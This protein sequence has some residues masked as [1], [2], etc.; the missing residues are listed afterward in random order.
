M[1]NHLLKALPVSIKTR[2]SCC[3]F[4]LT[5]H[6]Q[7]IV[8][9]LELFANNRKQQNLRWRKRSQNCLK[10]FPFSVIFIQ[11]VAYQYSLRDNNFAVNSTGYFLQNFV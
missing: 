9:Q 8:S 4:V 11:F 2:Q 3:S 6:F 5:V 7:L 10:A 1:I